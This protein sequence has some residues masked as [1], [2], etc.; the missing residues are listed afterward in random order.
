MVRRVRA[1]GALVI[2]SASACNLLYPLDGY[3]GGALDASTT[4]DTSP[5]SEAAT[6]PDAT[7]DGAL[8][9]AHATFP[10]RPTG[11][12]DGAFDL[13]YALNS[14]E[15][16][17]PSRSSRGF[18]LDDACTVDRATATCLTTR[19]REVPVDLANGVDNAGYPYLSLALVAP[20]AP[21][22]EGRYGIVVRVRNWN[23]LPD[24]P[25]VEV[26]VYNSPG[27]AA[28][29]AGALRAPRF[30]GTDTFDL[31]DEQ[32]PPSEG[33][34]PPKGELVALRSDESTAFVKDGVL[35]ANLVPDEYP[36]GTLHS[37]D[38][39]LTYTALRTDAARLPFS[40][41]L[42]SAKL[43]GTGVDAKLLDGTLAGTLSSDELLASL[44]FVRDPGAVGDAGPQH[45]CPGTSL[46]T[47]A[48]NKVCASLDLSTGDPDPESPCDGLS[49]VFGFSAVAVK[50]GSVVRATYTTSCA[51]PLA[52][53]EPCD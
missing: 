35:Y 44:P 53:P 26:T 9:C 7:P 41:V 51:A 5:P 32:S 15:L 34:P 52:Y 43:V 30:D 16:S 27:L 36:F 31:Y 49:G 21:L 33:Q 45:V 42:L 47:S 11:T 48:R 13:Y 46:Y 20:R 29:D 18:D 4:T 3:T 40:S 25:G 14:L 19:G 24:D 39:H 2:A 37:D 6:S 23:G 1:W 28:S 22:S 38:L 12:N 17:D 50:R 8:V 10:G